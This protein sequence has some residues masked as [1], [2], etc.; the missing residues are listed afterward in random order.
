MS[1][2]INGHSIE[3]WAKEIAY[4]I[5][6]ECFLVVPHP[7]ATTLL[8]TWLRNNPKVVIAMIGTDFIEEDYFE[9]D[10]TVCGGWDEL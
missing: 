2:L 4:R 8:E 7:E 9:T 1:E 6:D 3:E 5:S 10:E